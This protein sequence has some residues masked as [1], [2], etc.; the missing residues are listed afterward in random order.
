MFGYI[1]QNVH[2]DYSW[3]Q[4]DEDGPRDVLASSSLTEEGVEGIITTSNGL[5]TWHL[6]IRLY[7]MFQTVQLPACITHL[8]SGLT[9]M[10]RYT[11]TLKQSDN[12]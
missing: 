4:V 5:V 9:N 11:L 3:L 6:T 10:H 8:S 12:T 2:T 7:T 1:F